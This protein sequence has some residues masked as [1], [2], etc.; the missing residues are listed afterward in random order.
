MDFE[1]VHQSPRSGSLTRRRRTARKGDERSESRET[2]RDIFLRRLIRGPAAH[3]RVIRVVW[4]ACGLN[5]QGRGSRVRCEI[6]ASDQFGWC[7]FGEF[8]DDVSA[9]CPQ[10]LLG[11]SDVAGDR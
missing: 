3:V 10:L 2:L 11:Q 8:G 5:M 9:G 4:Y 6:R 1:C 7:L